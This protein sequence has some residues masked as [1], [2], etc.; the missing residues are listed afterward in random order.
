MFGRTN[1]N[2]LTI[3]YEG[4]E[5]KVYTYYNNYF[6]D[7]NG[8]ILKGWIEV[9]GNQERKPWV[10][11]SDNYCEIAYGG[12]SCTV[13]VT[14]L[15][16]DSIESVRLV[17]GEM[18]AYR[19]PGTDRDYYYIDGFNTGDVIEVT[20]A[21]GTVSRFTYQY[22][23]VGIYE[24]NFVNEDG[25][26]L[27]ITGQS[28]IGPNEN[29]WDLFVLGQTISG[30]FIIKDADVKSVSVKVNHQIYAKDYDYDG[31]TAA[32]GTE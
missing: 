32:D 31:F 15:G 25:V 7:E 8:Q 23:P 18:I 13:P 14:I 21:D 4:G 12:C 2:C 10:V 5:Q 24:K 27:N 19:V 1:G 30:T 26:V 3:T 6:R 29:S 17:S 9:Y 28:V 22:H 20:Y 11:G 16:H